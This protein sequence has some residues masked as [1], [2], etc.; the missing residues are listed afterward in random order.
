MAKEIPVEMP[1]LT[2]EEQKIVDLLTDRDIEAI[3]YELLTNS[4]T[5]RQKTAMVIAL[6]ISSLKKIYP[7]LPVLFY[8]DRIIKLVA[9]GK[10]QAYG[11]LKF[12]RFSEI[13]LIEK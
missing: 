2:D 5:H 1:P 7:N 9:E 11:N 12:I 6:T 3:D 13:E 4:K 10:L 8:S